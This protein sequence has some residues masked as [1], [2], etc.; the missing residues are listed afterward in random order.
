MEWIAVRS[1][2]DIETLIENE[3][4]NEDEAKASALQWM[5]FQKVPFEQISD[6]SWQQGN[7]IVYITQV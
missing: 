6:R 3:L 2:D 5:A 1:V 4:P 7:T